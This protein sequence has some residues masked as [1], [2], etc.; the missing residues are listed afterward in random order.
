MLASSLNFGL[1]IADL[2]C[3]LDAFVCQSGEVRPLVGR[4]QVFCPDGKGQAQGDDD[5]LPVAGGGLLVRGH[6]VAFV[7]VRAQETRALMHPFAIRNQTTSANV[8][9][10]RRKYSAPETRITSTTPTETAM[11]EP[12]CQLVP[13]KAQRKPSTTPAMGFRSI[14]SPPCG[15]NNHQKS[16]D[17]HQATRV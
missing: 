3:S 11:R 1:R 9:S 2:F 7:A 5:C 15:C 17:N 14:A 16:S 8:R 12:G 10:M 4:G 13:S 6:Q